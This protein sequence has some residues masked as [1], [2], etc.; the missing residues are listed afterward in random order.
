MAGTISKPAA[1]T[2]GG[3]SFRIWEKDRQRVEQDIVEGRP[4]DAF[5]TERG[6]F[7]AMLD[8]MLRSGL[9]AAATETRPSGLKKDNGIPYQLLNGVECLREMAGIDTPAN[10]GPLLKDAYLLER[11]GFTAE[12]IE[13]R[14]GQDHTI[15]DSE[16]LLN[17][18]GRFSEQ[19][20]E[21]CFTRHLEVIRRKRWLRGGVYAVDG[22]DILIPYGKGYEGARRIGEGA[23]GYKLLVLLNI[24]DG[25]ELIVGYILGG[26]QESEITMLRRLLARLDQTMG[27]LREWLKILLMDRGY[28][29]TDLFCELKQDYGIDFV[30][31][32]RDQKLDLNGAIQRQVEEAGRSWAD[33]EEERQFSGR[34]QTQKV[35]V[36][37]LRPITLI[38]DE[39]PH[40]EIAVNIVVAIQSHADGTAVLDKNGKDIS[41]TDYVASLAPGR[42]GVKVRG[43]Y[44]GRWGIENQGF[45]SL[46]QTWDIDRPAGHSYGAVLARLVFVFMIYNARHL[47]EKESQHRPDYAEHLR[48]MRS[49][50]PGIGLAG[51]AIVVLTASGCGTF[52]ARQLLQ[53]QKQRLRKALQRGLAEGRPLE[54]MM[55]ELDSS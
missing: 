40:R 4:F 5:V 8:F 6:R 28:W 27:P 15:I 3:D 48:Q 54:E 51:A 55:R 25:C 33:F 39:K 21:I 37:A 42:H 26:L 53:L 32:V 9:W 30:S 14:V 38:S 22:H 11:I 10:C 23:Y 18:L 50:G 43:F 16:S 29:G 17:H 2:A 24:Q 31:R 46:S 41:R 44:R 52:T 47:F 45:R 1:T 35:R 34:K 13:G 20:L 49:Y 12:K 19:D 36:T 7:D